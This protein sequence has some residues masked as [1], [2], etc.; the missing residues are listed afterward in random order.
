MNVSKTDRAASFRRKAEHNGVMKSHLQILETE[1]LELFEDKKDKLT[2]L[3]VEL[4]GPNDTFV[5]K[6]ALVKQLRAM[7]KQVA[8]DCYH[9]NILFALEQ[10]KRGVYIF[11]M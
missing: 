2:N 6:E 8:E 11:N 3:F 5:V 7:K 4:T 1:I 9:L 10:D